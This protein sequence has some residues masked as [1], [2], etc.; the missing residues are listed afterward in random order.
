MS[1]RFIHDREPAAPCLPKDH[2]LTG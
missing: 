1:F 2:G